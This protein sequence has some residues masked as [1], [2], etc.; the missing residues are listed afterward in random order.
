MKKAFLFLF[1]TGFYLTAISQDTGRVEF[2][3]LGIGFSIPD[4]WTGKE[5]NGAYLISSETERGFVIISAL[6]YRSITI[7]EEE[8]NAGLSLGDG[9]YISPVSAITRIDTA[10]LEGKISGLINYSPI[11][12]YLVILQGKD[13]RIIMILSAN[14]RELYSDKYKDLAVKIADE[15]SFFRAEMISI[16]REYQNLLNDSKLTFLESSTS[17]KKSSGAGYSKKIS[18]DLCSKG[19]FNYSGY[20]NEANN[21][22]VISGQ[23]PGNE[24]GA[25]KW[26]IYSNSNGRPVL[27]LNF[28]DGDVYE[29]RVEYIDGE[30]YLDGDPYFKTTKEDVGFD[31]DCF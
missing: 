8:L 30:I 27:K 13:K 12:A 28:Y 11:L 16:A 20:D 31:P 17:N 10:R 9:F 19:Y 29:Y 2:T 7:L 15:F 6:P 3:N 18:I 22:A 24:K 1:L 21:G 14:E 25:G 4:N 23:S 26:T 5:T